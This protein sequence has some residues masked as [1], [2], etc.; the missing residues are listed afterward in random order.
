MSGTLD[1]LKYY[2]SEDYVLV[3]KNAGGAAELMLKA[4]EI[5]QAYSEW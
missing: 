4:R 2:G 1:L 3:M 5:S